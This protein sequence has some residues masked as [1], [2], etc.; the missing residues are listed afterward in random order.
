MVMLWSVV[1]CDIV[2]K[3][4]ELRDAENDSVAKKILEE[5][6]T[7]QKASPQSPGW[8]IELLKETS[9]RTMLLD[10]IDK[11]Q[12]EQVQQLRHLSAHPVLGSADVLYRPNLE[13]TRACIRNALEALLLKSALFSKGIVNALL[14]DLES[15]RDSMLD[16]DVLKRYLEARFLPLGTPSALEDAMFQQLWIVAF[17]ARDARADANRAINV[18]AL[19]V[20]HQRRPAEVRAGMLVQADKFSRIG[21][22]KPLAALVRFLSLHPT[23]YE[24][25]NAAAKE[26]LRSLCDVD[27]NALAVARFL[28]PDLSE[29][30][31]KVGTALLRFDEDAPTSSSPKIS[32][33]SW[34]TVVQHA[35]D[36]EPQLQAAFVVGVEHY[37]RSRSY[38]EADAR[39]AQFVGPYVDEYEPETIRSLLEGIQGNSQLSARGR[40]KADHEALRSAAKSAGFKRRDYPIALEA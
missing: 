3:L 20:L 29:Y 13:T 26:P 27:I 33:A 23:L 17:K 15:R 12:L 40:A 9:K 16:I 2:Y 18:R 8:E 25:L 10:G 38:D 19:R 4:Q 35:R 34:K 31:A 39:F 21:A 30:V 36:S 1:V 7:L 37:A 22:G 11:V 5:M 28:S 24:P 6:E 32:S 14:E